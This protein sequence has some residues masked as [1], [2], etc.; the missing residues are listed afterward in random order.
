MT[1]LVDG[2]GA[3]QGV[4]PMMTST[5][6]LAEA[7]EATVKDTLEEVLGDVDL[8]DLED[9]PSRREIEDIDRRLDELE[10]FDPDDYVTTESLD[11]RLSDI[12][13]SM[14]EVTDLDPFDLQRAVNEHQD[15]VD[16][17]HSLQAQVKA[18]HEAS[19]TARMQRI[20]DAAR[21]RWGALAARLRR[22][23]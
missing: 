10:E 6:R 15:L 7:L 8:D 11:T 14:E 19:L 4:K 20:H 21:A 16:Q 12:E 17:V 1:Y 23:N 2:N 9:L 22:S 18:L 3:V 5:H 13:E